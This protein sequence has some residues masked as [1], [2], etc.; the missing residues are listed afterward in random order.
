MQHFFKDV[1][2]LGN[3]AVSRHAQ[4]KAEEFDI[5]EQKFKDVLFKGQDAPD[6]M[7]MLWRERN[8]IRL[9]ILL[10]PTQYTGARLVKTL[11]KVK[12]QERSR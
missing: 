9:V 2:R 3:V 11:Y 7:D 4:A 10:S 8:G 1:P 5:S 6:G 12:A